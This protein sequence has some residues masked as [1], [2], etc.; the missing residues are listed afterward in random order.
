MM[1]YNSLLLCKS[2]TKEHIVTQIRTLT[3]EERKEIYNELKKE[4]DNEWLFGIFYLNLNH[5]EQMLYLCVQILILYFHF[6]L[7]IEPSLLWILHA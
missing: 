3:E 1:E 6:C 7:L 5:K 4:F 2:K